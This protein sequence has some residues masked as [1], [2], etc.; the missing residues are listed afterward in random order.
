MDNPLCK[1]GANGFTVIEL[2]VAF[3]I[4][5]VL[6]VFFVIQRNNLEV[7]SRDA[8]RKMAVNAM[9]YD[10]TEVFYAQYKYYPETISRTNLTALDPTLFTDPD[11]FT[12]DGNKCAYTDADG[13]KAT[14]GNCNYHYTSSN[15][16]AK[17][18]CQA[19][20]LTADMEAEAIFAKTSPQK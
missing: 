10:L 12:L 3:V 8:T 13:N 11:G 9:Y 6:T 4:L 16:N 5:V 14:D 2:V 7:A 1:R 17:G 20:K 19:F 18:E 15:C